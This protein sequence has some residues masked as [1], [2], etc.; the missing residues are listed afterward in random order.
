[1]KQ[2][3]NKTFDKISYM[4]FCIAVFF[5]FYL[6]GVSSVKWKI[7]PY[8]SL[9]NA[10]QAGKAVVEKLKPANPFDSTF[11]HISRHEIT[12]V[13]QYDEKEAENGF[14]FF[15]YGLDQ[16]A[17]LI[18]MD[19]SIVHKWHLPF[20][21]IWENPPHIKFPVKDHLINLIAPY[22]YLNG[23]ILAIYATDRD[24]PFGY[25]LVKMDKNSKI[26]WKSSVRAHHDAD[27]DIDGNVYV[28]THEMINRKIRNVT[29]PPPVMDDFVVILSPEGKE[30]DKVSITDAFANSS[31]SDVLSNLSNWDLWHTNSIKVL[32][33]NNLK[34][35]PFLERGCVLVSMKALHAIAAI[36]LK[37]KK[38]IWAM[39]GPWDGQ[40][41]ADFLENG[42][43][44]IFDN[45]GHFGEGGRS[46]ILEFNPLTL[47][48][49]W[50]YTGDKT[51]YF[52]SAIRSSQQR[53]A[54]GNTLI[55][56]SDNG[57]IFEV[58]KSNKIVWEFYIPFR[59]PGNSKYTAV[60]LN[61]QRFKRETLNFTFNN[62]EM[63]K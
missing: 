62:G 18:S 10:F 14:T 53:L 60:A 32:H 52:F 5:L 58:T 38:V 37:L 12:G 3:G 1:M 28:L 54:N 35:F 8:P 19:G 45:K 33:E 55:T 41:D 42:N 39:R 56:E 29:V 43:L 40:H 51:K 17:L 26:I 63:T 4:W 7:W 25:G 6:F 50:D 30:I 27:V 23:D 16:N 36:D 49:L 22:L 24:T 48:T 59:V 44:L 2:S 21:K 11:Y 34:T 57:R 9:E 47:E 20:S 46:R 13:I 15:S 31:Y 61:A